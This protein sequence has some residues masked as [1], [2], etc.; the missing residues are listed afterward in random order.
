MKGIHFSGRQKAG[1]YVR[2]GALLGLLSLL[3]TG[4]YYMSKS[5]HSPSAD[6]SSKPVPEKVKWVSNTH[7]YKIMER[8]ANDN[9]S[10]PLYEFPAISIVKSKQPQGMQATVKKGRIL[11]QH[12]APDHTKAYFFVQRSELQEGQP[13]TQVDLVG[14]DPGSQAIVQEPIGLT[15]GLPPEIAGDSTRLCGFL[16]ADDFLYTAIHNKGEEWVYEVD[17][18]NLASRK[19]TPVIELLHVP[20]DAGSYPMLLGAG[21][22][23]D[24]RHVLIRD[25]KHG[26]VLY[27]LKTG[28]AAIELPAAGEKRAGE[29][30]VQ[31]PSSE[32]MLYGAG[33]FQNDLW[34]IDLNNGTVK[35]P[36]TAEQ[37]LIDA[38]MDASGKIVFYNFSYERGAEHVLSGEKRSLLKSFGV[39]LLDLKGNPIKRFSLPKDSADRLEY[40]GYSEEKKLVLLH[41]YTV[42]AGSK[43]PYKKTSGWLLGDIT[44]GAM[45]PLVPVDVPDNWDKKDVVFGNVLT[46]AVNNSP[47][48]QAFANIQDRTVYMTKWRT[49][50][51][52]VQTEEDRILFINEPS[53]RVFVSSLTRP[54]LIV[55]ALNYKKYNW[56]NRDFAL[57]RGRYLSRYQAL[58]DGD[59]MYFFQIN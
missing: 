45:T 27:D 33:L 53:K 9:P 18:F 6:V 38:G 15:Q 14:I 36:F 40:A 52:T 31:F 51:L 46:D 54:D 20:K 50:Q 55:A 2:V 32:V 5:V 43:G 47:G 39:Q 56:D 7:D 42:A 37:G 1:P 12:A 59:R 41:K 23:P 10:L 58:P 34:W 22:S 28:A 44:S 30:F 35:Q 48:A 21:L 13:W 24:K 16:S 11:E 4:V 26:L 49:K 17:R 29:T 3:F 8:F 19:V 57:L 25:T